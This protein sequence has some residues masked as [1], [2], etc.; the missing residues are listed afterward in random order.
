MAMRLGCHKW[1]FGN[2]TVAEAAA[3]TRALGLDYLD[4]GNGGDLEP[5]YIAAH[6]AEEAARF[7]RIRQE[8]GI[9]FVDCFPQVSEGGVAFTNNHP[10]AAVRA[11]YREVWRGFFAFA[12]AIGL[13]GITLS[14]G[15]YWPGE[16]AQAG[17]ERGAEELRWAVA[18]GAGRGLRVRIEPHI[19]SVTWRP[20]LVVRMV[21]A[22]PGLTLTL[23]HSHF[24]FHALPYEQIATMHPYGTHWHARQ[25]RPGSAQS[26]GH[27]G[28]IDFARIVADLRARH[29]DGV[30]CLEY[31]HGTWMSQTNVDCLSETVA[32]RDELRGY[33]AG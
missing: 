10:D 18:E 15:R 26:P 19:E 14:P 31:V 5:L 4:L 24:I 21:E 23:D 3:I 11:R 8:T 22:V 1:T 20:E 27:E 16:P 25:A 33:L 6:P 29:Y 12:A 17:F 2:C 30:I 28:Q 9:T 7:N 32:L 13:E